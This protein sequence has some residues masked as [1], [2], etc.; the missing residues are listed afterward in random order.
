MPNGITQ[1]N[2]SQ[3]VLRHIYKQIQDGTLK[4]GDKLPTNRGLAEELGVSILTVQRS[5]KQLEAQGTVTCHR[6]TGTF[7]TN[8]DTINSPKIQ[9]GLIGLF[10]PEFLAD[11]QTDLMIELEQGLME[12]G[13]LLSINFTHSEPEREI[14]LL[15]TLARQRLE[16]LV[17]FT[18][19]L[20][21]SSEAHTRT[22]TSWINRYVEE[23]TQVLFADLCPPG[24]ES[25]LISMD[26]AQ[27]GFMLTNKLIERGHKN[28]AFF[29]P[30]HLRGASNRLA[31]H[32]KALKKAGLPV[33]EDWHLD[34]RIMESEGWEKQI[35]KPTRELLSLYPDLT[36]F[37]ISTQA[38]AEAV[39]RVLKELPDRAFPAEASIASLLETA[40]PPFE[41]AAWI[42]LPGKKMGE[43][44][45]EI[46]LGNHPADYEPGHI[47]IRPTFWAG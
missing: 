6:R 30:T 8:P 24:F 23:G 22:V 12:Q 11:F 20:V 34:V 39:Y 44:A 19:P 32:Y 42:K 28:I 13:K 38:T 36:G 14:N 5:M 27:A 9:S 17:Y 46:V 4:T 43:K 45:R 16:A 35:E 10:V 37:V 18:S 40:T 2:L 3:Q 1:P 47:K 15:R 26:N 29:G 33:N 21:V 41:A 7:L 25:R 31:G